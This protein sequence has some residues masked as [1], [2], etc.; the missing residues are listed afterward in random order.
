MRERKW[1]ARI[2]AIVAFVLLFSVAMTACGNTSQGTQTTAG[3]KDTVFGIGEVAQ[4]KNGQ[5]SLLSVTERTGSDFNKPA[6]GK[7]YVLCEFE[8]TNNSDSELAISSMLSFKAYCDDYACS[9]SIGALLEK[10]DSNQLD[11]TVAA[12]KKLKGVIGYE[13]PV[14]WKELEIHFTPDIWSSETLVFAAANS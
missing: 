14:E 5:V 8:I 6:E 4:M 13:L 11:G 10:G 1:K 12:G 2:A 9:Y 3:N 7:I